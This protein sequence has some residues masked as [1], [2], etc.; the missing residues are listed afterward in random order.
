MSHYMTEDAA[1]SFVKK[2]MEVFGEEHRTFLMQL[3]IV[4]KWKK[5]YSWLESRKHAESIHESEA[6]ETSQTTHL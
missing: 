2:S 5:A 4:H 1:L 3:S 6:F